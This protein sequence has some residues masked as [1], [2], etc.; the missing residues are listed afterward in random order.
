MCNRAVVDEFTGGKSNISPEGLNPGGLEEDGVC[1]LELPPQ[2]CT[3]GSSL[4][5]IEF[6]YGI[7]PPLGRPQLPC[8]WQHILESILYLCREP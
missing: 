5:T 2:A 3:R 7:T 1:P 6:M 8:A 4:G